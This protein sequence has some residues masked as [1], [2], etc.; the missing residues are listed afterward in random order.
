MINY[1]HQE[2]NKPD[3]V[4]RPTEKERRADEKLVSVSWLFVYFAFAGLIL[5]LADASIC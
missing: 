5:S 4:I 2:D 1:S 3:V